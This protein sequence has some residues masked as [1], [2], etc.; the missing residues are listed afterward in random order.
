MLSLKFIR[1]NIDKVKLTLKHKNVDFDLE[2]LLS[3]D[4]ERPP[5]PPH[6]HPPRLHPHT[7]THTTAP[8]P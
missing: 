4:D 6:T 2:D 7:H 8:A 1:E 3:Q 5:C